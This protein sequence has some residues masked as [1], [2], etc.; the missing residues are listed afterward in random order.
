MIK[1]DICGGKVHFLR[2]AY[3]KWYLWDQKAFL[4][5]VYYKTAPQKKQF[6][7][8]SAP[9]NIVSTSISLKHKLFTY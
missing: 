5:Y 9:A 2:Y 4:K 7:H 1:S 3:Y 8:A 6:T